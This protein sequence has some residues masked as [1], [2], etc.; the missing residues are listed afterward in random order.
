MGWHDDSDDEWALAWLTCR[1]FPS[2]P[3][4]HPCSTVPYEF[5]LLLLSTDCRWRKRLLHALGTADEESQL[6]T[7]RQ[8][9]NHNM[10]SNFAA[11]ARMELLLFSTP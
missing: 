9:A 6:T 8:T 1:H 2:N 7:G 3:R 10:I 5:N 11:P 4:H